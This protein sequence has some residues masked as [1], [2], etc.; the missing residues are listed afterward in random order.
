[1][2]G[3][4]DERAFRDIGENGLRG[5]VRATQDRRWKD[6]PRDPVSASILA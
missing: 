4:V 1:M 2:T 5:S 6:N 3:E